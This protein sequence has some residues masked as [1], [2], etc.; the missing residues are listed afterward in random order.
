MVTHQLVCMFSALISPCVFYQ[1]FWNTASFTSV[2]F[3]F[4]LRGSPF[5]LS[6]MLAYIHA[7]HPTLPPLLPWFPALLHLCTRSLRHSLMAVQCCC[8]GPLPFPPHSVAINT[9]AR[10]LISKMYWLAPLPPPTTTTHLDAQTPTLP[11]GPGLRLM[12][13]NHQ[14][15]HNMMSNRATLSS[16]DL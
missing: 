12:P 13:P 15:L 7:A 6:I 5:Y 8:P 4:R 10:W 2:P 3:S 14:N 11:M 9:Q 16:S 1:V